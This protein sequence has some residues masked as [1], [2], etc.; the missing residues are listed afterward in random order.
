MCK[1]KSSSSTRN[2][3]ISQDQASATYEHPYCTL[4]SINVKLIKGE[5]NPF[6]F[7]PLDP[8]LFSLTH[9]MQTF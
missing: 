8:P 3:Q 6:H 7:F 9:L 2:H 5:D 4:M 1:I